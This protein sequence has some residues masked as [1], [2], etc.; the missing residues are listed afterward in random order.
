VA[1][2]DPRPG[3]TIL[4]LAAGLGDTGFAAAGRLGAEGKLLSTDVAPEMVAAAGRRAAELGVDNVELRVL[5]ATSID[6]PDA[7]VDGVLYR[8][9][10]MLVADPPRA[11]AEIA[12]VLR[13]GGRVSLAV[14][15]ASDENEWMTAVGRCAVQLG[16]AERPDPRAPGPF[17]FAGVGELRGLLEQAGL[18][19]T[20]VEDVPVRWRA[21]SVAEWWDA[22]RDMSPMLNG[23][24]EQISAEQV[25]ALRRG[26]AA[27]LAPYVAPDG[28][29]SVPG[30]AR[31]LLATRG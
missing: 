5:D 12:R 19:V 11:L 7:A 3:E 17:R 16:L 14:W 30:R 8:F 15:A 29:L 31:A 22:V 20:T 9:G 25:T 1:L 23:L 27:L 10:I 18:G 24:L 2:L 28:S 13:P 6:L 26:A 4:E 21:A